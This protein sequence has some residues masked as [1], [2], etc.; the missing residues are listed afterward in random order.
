MKK[1]LSIVAA[2]IIVIGGVIAWQRTPTVPQSQGAVTS[3]EI[4]DNHIS[5]NGVTTWT[6]RMNMVAATTTPCSFPN[7]A[8]AGTSTTAGGVPIPVVGMA[9]STLINFSIQVNTGTGTS[10]TFDIATSTTPYATSTPSLIYAASIASGAQYSQLF[11]TS[12]QG[13]ATSS[14]VRLISSMPFDG[15]IIK[16][17][18]FVNFK[19]AGLGV[20]GYTYGGQ[21]IAVFRSVNAF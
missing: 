13:N 8:G 10:A 20:G 3:P 15:N 14:D 2:F 4:N 9:T 1:I 11:T 17:A 16:P 18:E 19:T 5:I 7:P 6:L 21:C 12:A